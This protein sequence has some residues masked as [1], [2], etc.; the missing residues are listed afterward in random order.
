MQIPEGTEYHEVLFMTE[1]RAMSFNV[2]F[3][4]YSYDAINGYIQ[5]NYIDSEKI[6]PK[7]WTQMKYVK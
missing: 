7:R 5:K 6:F 1:D 4:G 3:F 2:C